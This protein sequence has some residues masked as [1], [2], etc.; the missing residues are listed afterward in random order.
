MQTLNVGAGRTDEE[1]KDAEER[2]LADLR[3][4]PD[5]CE[6]FLLG[7]RGRYVGTG[8]LPIKLNFLV[9]IGAIDLFNWTWRAP[10]LSFRLSTWHDSVW[11]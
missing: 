5:R 9:N 6:L 7:R 11:V 10:R 4:Q 3:R 8:L 2:R 1:Y